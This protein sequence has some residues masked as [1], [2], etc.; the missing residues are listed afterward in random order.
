MDP[1]DYIRKILL[2]QGSMS[3]TSLFGYVKL[4]P[5]V[6]AV[7]GSNLEA[8]RQLILNKSD[9]FEIETKPSFTLENDFTANTSRPT[10]TVRLINHQR[11][12]AVIYSLAGHLSE[13]Q[14]CEQNSSPSELKENSFYE[15]S[16]HVS[17]LDK[18]FLA[19][20]QHDTHTFN[21]YRSLPNSNLDDS[22]SAM[23]NVISSQESLK[24]ETE[25]WSYSRY[26][27]IYG[28]AFPDHPSGSNIEKQKP[29]V[30]LRHL[31]KSSSIHLPSGHSSITGAEAVIYK[32]H[33][34]SCFARLQ[35][36]ED[37]YIPLEA[38]SDA[39]QPFVKMADIVSFGL[40]V[41]V[42]AHVTEHQRCQWRATKMR[43]GSRSHVLNESKTDVSGIGMFIYKIIENYGRCLSIEKLFSLYQD[44]YSNYRGLFGDCEELLHEIANDNRF[45][46]VQAE[47]KVY[48]RK[49]VE[50][51]ALSFL[52]NTI[53][54][55]GELNSEALKDQHVLP[56]VGEI[57]GKDSVTGKYTW[58]KTEM[59]CLNQEELNVVDG[60]IYRVD[61][62][63]DSKFTNSCDKI[64]FWDDYEIVYERYPG[65]KFDFSGMHV[66]S[67]A[68]AASASP[69][70][71]N[72]NVGLESDNSCVDNSRQNESTVSFTE[73][74]F[75]SVLPK[76]VTNVSRLNIS[77]EESFHPTL[78]QSV[79]DFIRSNGP[80]KLEVLWE[81]VLDKFKPEFIGLQHCFHQL[82]EKEEQLLLCVLDNTVHI[83]QTVEEKALQ[84]VISKIETLGPLDFVSLVCHLSSA[85]AE[86]QYLLQ[87][88]DGSN[89]SKAVCADQMRIFLSRY[90]DQ[91]ILDGDTVLLAN[92]ITSYTYSGDDVLDEGTSLVQ[93]SEAD[94][95]YEEGMQ[96]ISK[97]A[98]K[99]TVSFRSQDLSDD[100]LK[101]SL[102]F[103]KLESAVDHEQCTESKREGFA[104]SL[105]IRLASEKVSVSHVI[106]SNDDVKGFIISCTSNNCILVLENASVLSFTNFYANGSIFSCQE[107][108]MK[109]GSIIRIKQQVYSDI[110]SGYYVNATVEPCCWTS[111]KYWLGSVVAVSSEAVHVRSLSGQLCEIPAAK[112]HSVHHCTNPGRH[113]V[114]ADVIAINSDPGTNTLVIFAILSDKNASYLESKVQPI[115]CCS[116]SDIFCGRG[117]VSVL[118]SDFVSIQMASG[119]MASCLGNFLCQLQLE[120]TVLFSASR[121]EDFISK[122]KATDV[123]KEMEDLSLFS[124][125]NSDARNGQHLIEMQSPSASTC[126]HSNLLTC[127]VASQTNSTGNIMTM[128]WYSDGGLRE[129]KT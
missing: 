14:E 101:S 129:N 117:I 127:N 21:L 50:R 68:T 31:S 35:N 128:R 46:V 29:N 121:S 66:L 120:D 47:R 38:I 28:E 103:L 43:F 42:D 64:T 79:L 100:K 37:V 61:S 93:T 65:L 49:D 122:W 90:T 95:G 18:E 55:Y 115:V 32:I 99:A 102:E 56:S 41:V 87:S 1:V 53:N 112:W 89:I 44:I 72:E 76:S 23:P 24:V 9:E 67:F 119:E 85:A 78:I 33:N 86:V 91:L 125:P 52:L 116:K 27:E 113:L 80:V 13:E 124:S 118:S 109:K 51:L 94:I 62:R 11:R 26:E 25:D 73:N 4:C 36:Q 83:K 63:P 45:L 75:D 17:H 22:T 107:P 126:A 69:V 105:D 60:K 10:E 57:L 111:S 15:S 114:V 106:D 108:V 2:V 54:I 5:S 8:L 74:V 20:L 59:F 6:V 3:L 48:I 39:L 96:S 19:L 110:I 97:T 34:K 12:D 7:I 81:F 70:Y 77:G 30:L 88:R 92:D 82:M 123:R 16:S 104:G 84:F 98:E 71:S 40:R 58:A